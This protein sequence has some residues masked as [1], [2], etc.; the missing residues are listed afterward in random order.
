MMSLL[1]TFFVLLVSFANFESQ[2]IKEAIVSLNGALGVMRP[3]VNVVT[4]PDV[5][6]PRM[7]KKPP[8]EGSE[9]E[10]FR[11]KKLEV[12]A[13]L[14]R[15]GL[16]QTIGAHVSKEGI[17]LV[18]LRP[19]LFDP[20]SAVLRQDSYETLSLIAEIIDMYDND[21]RVEGHTSDATPEAG[22][23]Y[24]TNW[25]LSGARA[26]AIVRYFAE[27]HGVDPKRL[28]YIG[29]GPTRPA[30]S[31]RTAIGKA[32]NDRVV[33]NLV[34]SQDPSGIG[35]HLKASH[36]EIPRDTETVAPA[37]PDTE[38]NPRAP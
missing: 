24:P 36:K 32:H 25:E 14:K 20:G 37:V 5:P 28:S 34:S 26:C 12:E 9:D 23:P 21:V 3:S 4:M 35:E 8:N 15:K 27:R 29:Y 19:A 10:E 6:F 18:A 2:K 38:E 7:Q 22:S 31:N 30:V 1:L 11:K 17:K 33:V 16:D 13:Q